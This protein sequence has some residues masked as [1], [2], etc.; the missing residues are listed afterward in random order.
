[1]Y[2]PKLKTADD[3]RPFAL[4]LC[5]PVSGLKVSDLTGYT[6]IFLKK[7]IHRIAWVAPTIS[8]L[9]PGTGDPSGHFYFDS[10]ITAF[11]TGCLMV[12]QNSEIVGSTVIH[13]EAI[14]IYKTKLLTS[15]NS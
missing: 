9:A 2:F 8:E 5:S 6:W 13:T 14:R 3:P 7:K 1:M 11:R 4:F 12:L 15:R 10:L